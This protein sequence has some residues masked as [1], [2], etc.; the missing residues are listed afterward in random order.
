MGDQFWRPISVD[1]LD[2]DTFPDIALYFKTGG[3][4]ILYKNADCKL[5]E[6][7]QQ[8]IKNNRIDFVY[9][10][11][12]NLQKVNQ[13]LTQ[14]LHQV[15]KKEDLDNTEKSRF[16]YQTSINHVVDIF[17]NPEQS[18]CLDRCRILIRQMMDYI[19][20]DELAFRS[21]ISIVSCDN[22]IFS[23]A[24]QVTALNLLLHEKIFNLIPDEMV[25]VG[26]GSLLHDFGMTFISDELLEK[27]DKLTAEEYLVVKTHTE[28]GYKQLKKLGLGE[29]ALH[30]VRYHHERYNGSG[31]PF[32]MQ[33][34]DIPRSAQLAAICDT[35]SALIHKRSYRPALSQ[36][37]AL[38]ELSR[39]AA[40][41]LF[42]EAYCS[43]FEKM[44]NATKGVSEEERDCLKSFSAGQDESV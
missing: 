36:T 38:A 11:V 19:V 15:L 20:K 37:N 14:N 1:C 42:N 29:V 23:H 31:Y 25:E 6:T 12:G 10:H 5:T 28:D 39:L 3:R 32:G 44:I 17:E 26:I 9:V 27:P 22:Y 35:Y 2:P 41:G 18:A 30:V 7:D 24:V 16:L 40:D 21:L 8:R 13:Y 34:N 43:R 4:Y 33:E